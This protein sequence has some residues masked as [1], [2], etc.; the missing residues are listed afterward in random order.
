MA[1]QEKAV[2][3]ATTDTEVY[4]C[5]VGASG[6]VHGLV[7]SNVT[8]AAATIALKL[9]SQATGLVTV[10]AAARQVPANSEFTWPKPINMTAGDKI[11]ATGS[12][13][14]AVVVVAS[15]FLGLAEEPSAGFNPRGA[16]DAIS[17][18]SKNDVVYHDKISYI[19]VAPNINSQPPSNDW[20]VSAE[21]VVGPA[22]GAGSFLDHG[23]VV[24]GGTVA[25]NYST[26]EMHRVQVGSALTLSTEGW[27]PSG[28]LA[29]MVI[30]LV[31][32][33]SYAVTWP[34]INWVL[35]DGT[36]TTNFTN[37]GVTLQTVGTDWVLLWTRDGGATICGRVMR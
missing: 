10:L 36:F 35:G 8:G 28:Q 25:L 29:E 30:E 6:S 15:V 20:M 32:G 22:G 34:T 31:N 21:S 7:F 24:A 2:S 13:A 9:F 5:P 37:T 23:A 3:L 14:N 17:N 1:F 4:L 18:Y 19:A 33:G 26:A 12:V 16:W 27:T 11:I